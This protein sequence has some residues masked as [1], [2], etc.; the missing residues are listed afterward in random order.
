MKKR[1]VVIAVALLATGSGYFGYLY[2]FKTNE[3]YQK[4]CDR[5]YMPGCF[6]LGISYDVG[7]GVKQDYFKASKLFQK[8]CDGGYMK[9]CF[10]LGNSYVRGKGVKQNYSKAK[11]LYQKVCESGEQ[12]GCNNYKLLNEKGH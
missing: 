4:A 6:S 12:K 9:G 10:N 2:Y 7:R 5:G 1:I 8:A 11:A 3:L